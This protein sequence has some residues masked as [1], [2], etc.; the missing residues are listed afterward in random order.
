MKSYF[1]TNRVLAWAFTG[2]LT[3]GLFFACKKD[4]NNNKPSTD[5]VV[6]NQNDNQVI[7]TAG[8]ETQINAIYSDVF[9]SV[10]SASTGQGLNRVAVGDKS[11]QATATGD[12]PTTTLDNANPGVWPKT[13]TIN[14]G[15]SCSSSNFVGVRGGI[16]N[17][18]FSAPLLSGTATVTVTFSNYTVNGYPVSG[19]LTY[20]NIIYK[21][22]SDSAF[23]YSTKITDGKV[24]LNDTTYIVYNST[25][26]IQ[27]IAGGKTAVNPGDDVYKAS[28]SGTIAYTDAAGTTQKYVAAFSTPVALEKAWSCQWISKGQLQVVIGTVTGTL[29]Y[30]DGTCDNKATITV[31]D[32]VKDI[33]LK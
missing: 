25:K 13:V 23:S 10:S 29:D 4:A 30:G 9:E 22:N 28:G 12:C 16:V 27:Q 8:H 18:T 2:I 14:Y 20:S 26:T 21:Q 32:K 19:T 1:S 7:L 6:S 31:G 33:T 17:A 3:T 24:K 11:L 15:S 5:P